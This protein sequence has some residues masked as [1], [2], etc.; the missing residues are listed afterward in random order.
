M[1]CNE[2]CFIHCFNM[3]LE[4]AINVYSI[5][6]NFIKA[7]TSYISIAFYV[8]KTHTYSTVQA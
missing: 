2:L 5:R 8:I 4:S 1:H 6:V 7:R 3:D